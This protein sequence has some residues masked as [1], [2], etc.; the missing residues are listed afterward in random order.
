M[1][2][3]LPFIKLDFLTIK[4]YLTGKNTIIMVFLPIFLMWGNRSAPFAAGFLMLFGTLFISY[5]FSAGERNGIDLLYATLSITRKTVVLGRYLFAL[6]LNL[7]A[8]VLAYILIFLASMLLKIDFQHG[9]I[10]SLVL[11][12][13]IVY[14]IVQAFQL[15]FYFK[16]G[17]AKARFIIYIPLA[18][19]PFIVAMLSTQIQSSGLAAN[20]YGVLIWLENNPSLLIAACIVLWLVIEFVSYS[21]ALKFYQKR[22]F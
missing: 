15:P 5:P 2:K 16:L 18:A 12:L 7:C 1:S 20:L 11:A 3:V 8:G 13:L 4:P 19:F 6:V 21:F 22:D 14:S 17:Y 9:S 10:I